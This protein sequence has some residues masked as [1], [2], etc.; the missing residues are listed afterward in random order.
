MLDLRF[1]CCC[2]EYPRDCNIRIN[3][4]TTSQ[5]FCYLVQHQG[6]RW[7]CVVAKVIGLLLRI[8][9]FSTFC[10]CRVLLLV[11]QFIQTCLFTCGWNVMRFK[12]LSIQCTKDCKGC[13]SSRTWSVR[14]GSHYG[15]ELFILIC[16]STVFDKYSKCANIFVTGW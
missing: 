16:P 3:P 15:C 6:W 7:C 11:S 5:S 9:K 8:L 1:C 4:M 14:Y 10:K 2:A 12:T 13:W